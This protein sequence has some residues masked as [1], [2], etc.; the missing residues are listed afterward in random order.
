MAPSHRHKGSAIALY[1]WH[2]GFAPDRIL[3]ARIETAKAWG[4]DA[5]CKSVCGLKLLTKVLII[6][7]DKKGKPRSIR[8]GTEDL[9]A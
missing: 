6:A 8:N 5:S 9:F 7:I 1:Q 4:V 3:R 2:V